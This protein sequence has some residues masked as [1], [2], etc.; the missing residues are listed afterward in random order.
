MDKARILKALQEFQAQE[1]P[2][3]RGPCFV[4]L[5]LAIETGLKDR[6]VTS[7]QLLEWLGPPDLLD[8]KD[9]NAFYVYRFDHEEAGSDRD[10]WY[11]HIRGGV[12][13]SSG[14]NRKGINDH[15]AMLP[16]VKPP[17]ADS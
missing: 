16:G 12:M 17:R 7:G 10:E 6:S 1:S 11:F 5:G 2:D 9:D 4:R 13:T 14:Y 8:E 15:S 3:K